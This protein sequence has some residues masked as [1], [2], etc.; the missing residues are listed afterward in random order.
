LSPS[1]PPRA[2]VLGVG[3]SRVNLATAVRTIAGWVER[4]EHAYV[5]IRDAHG[6]VLCQHDEELRRI[7]NDAGMVTPDGMP[8][9]WFCR[10]LGFKDVARVYGPDLMCAVLADEALRRRRHFLLG[11]A[12]GV[13]GE[14]ARTLGERFPGFKPVG[15]Y[16]PPAEAT[17]EGVDPR[18]IGLMRDSGAEIVWVGLGSP[19]QER[20]MARHLPHASVAA[21]I[22]VGAAFDFLSGRKA[23]APRWMQG[24]GFEWAFR[25]ATE[26]RRLAGR[27]LKTVPAFVMLAAL[28]ATGLRRFP[29][30]DDGPMQATGDR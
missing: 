18:A 27:Y 21:M 6:V 7:H 9:V 22:G 15:V 10:A 19:K 1:R 20:W 29:P 14:L 16:A 3:I 2:N 25:L 4:D 23:Q 8:L 17:R 26:P 5:C 28:A 30:P 12:P 11:G 24:S 13:A